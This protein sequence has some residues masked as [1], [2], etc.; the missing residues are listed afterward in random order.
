V[1][2]KATRRSKRTVRWIAQGAP[3]IDHFS[4]LEFQEGHY[5]KCQIAQV[6]ESPET[7][8]LDFK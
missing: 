2:G 1:L 5:L 7:P 3:S 8:H 4:R 6:A